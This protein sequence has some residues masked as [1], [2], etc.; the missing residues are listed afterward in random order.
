MSVAEPLW[1]E[2]K[3]KHKY[4]RVS[5][6]LF[7][8]A[9]IYSLWIALLII[10][11]FYLELGNKWAVLTT[12]QWILIGIFI[13]AVIIGLEMIL[14]LHYSL[15]KR[16]YLQPEHPPQPVYLQGKQVYSY[17]VPVDAKGGIF[18]KTYIMIDQTRVLNLRYQMILPN[19][20]WGQKQ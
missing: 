15:S 17:T 18:S 5:R 16:R 12:E 11:A 3:Q 2:E 19:E 10:G 7:L 8:F 20:L 6:I 9:M 4:L 1:D 13:I 14:L